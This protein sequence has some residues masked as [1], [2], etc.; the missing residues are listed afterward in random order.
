M[1]TV[2]PGSP[3]TPGATPSREGLPETAV[4]TNG[5][6]TVSNPFRIGP[7]VVVSCRSIVV[8]DPG[9]KTDFR[10]FGRFPPMTAAHSSTPPH[11]VPRRGEL[12]AEVTR[13]VEKLEQE[14]QQVRHALATR[15]PIEQAKGMLM[16][17]YGIPE[18]RAFQ[19]LVR[20]STHLNV[21]LRTV[22]RT[23]VTVCAD[24]HQVACQALTPE[25]LVYQVLSGARSLPT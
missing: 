19:V 10:R 3:W 8:R 23:F 11:V 21:R 5:F 17:R 24:D 18:D 22:A 16:I 20:W 13:H 25:Q 15:A 9:G 4:A 14:L 12:P 1:P 6:F 7:I 2:G